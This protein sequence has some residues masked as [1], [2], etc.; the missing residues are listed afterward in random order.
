MSASPDEMK[1]LLALISKIDEE[2]VRQLNGA[3]K[4]RRTVATMV[5]ISNFHV[6]DKVR[7]TGKAGDAA[8][9]VVQKVKQKY[10]LVVQDGPRNLHWN[11]PATMLT[12]VQ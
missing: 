11:I 1:T 10:V 4:A 9:G 12:R 3:L 6:G 2:Q 8:T 7:W 5:A